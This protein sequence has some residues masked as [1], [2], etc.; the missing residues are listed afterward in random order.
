MSCL[1][2][3]YRSRQEAKNAAKRILNV[4]GYILFDYRC[5]ICEQ[6]HLTKIN[7]S[8]IS[9]KDRENIN[10]FQERMRNRED[11][12]RNAKFEKYTKKKKK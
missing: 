3:K 8:K 2:E 11:N 6:F 4:K 1:K 12:I 9:E 5:K 10:G 7:I